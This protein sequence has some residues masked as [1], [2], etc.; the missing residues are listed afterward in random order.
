MKVALDIHIAHNMLSIMI[1]IMLAY[2]SAFALWKKQFIQ[3]WFASC[4]V[5]TTQNIHIILPRIAFDSTELQFCYKLCDAIYHF[6]GTHPILL[7]I[8][9]HCQNMRSG[10]II[11]ALS[12]SRNPTYILDMS[13]QHTFIVSYYTY[14]TSTPHY[15]KMPPAKIAKTT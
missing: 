9:I 11:P 6:K 15:K 12:S 2:P 1:P 14:A 10:E 5:K 7:T 8:L 4:N 3:F 13:L